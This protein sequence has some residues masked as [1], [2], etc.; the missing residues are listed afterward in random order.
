[1]FNV[2]LAREKLQRAYGALN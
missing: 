1:M 2:E